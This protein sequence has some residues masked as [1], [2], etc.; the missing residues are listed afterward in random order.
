MHSPG[1]SVGSPSFRRIVT[2]F[3]RWCQATERCSER[4]CNDGEGSACLRKWTT[5]NWALDSVMESSAWMDY[6]ILTCHA[7]A[8]TYVY[9]S[10]RFTLLKADVHFTTCLSL[11]SILSLS[12]LLPE[13]E[14][15]WPCRTYSLLG[16][17]HTRRV[18]KNV[19]LANPLFP[20]V[21]VHLLSAAR[22][23][24]LVFFR[25]A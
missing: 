13:S 23:V 5:I 19:T 3:G 25:C 7:R 1:V 11:K 2:K 6:L 14:L 17:E 21:R 12:F 8:H 10:C 18:S 20:M 16:Y 22:R 24:F 9:Q 15:P 4:G